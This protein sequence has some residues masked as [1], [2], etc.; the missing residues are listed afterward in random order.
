MPLIVRLEGTN[1]TEARRIIK[2]SG[3]DIQTA[4]DLD[5]AAKKAVANAV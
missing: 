5:D 4:E 1:A 3:L 2:E